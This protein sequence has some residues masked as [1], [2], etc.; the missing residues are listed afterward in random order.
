MSDFHEGRVAA[1]FLM[2][3]R[4]ENV[5]E[6]YESEVVRFDAVKTGFAMAGARLEEYRAKVREDTTTG[7][8]ALK[9]GECAN[10]YIS[11]CVEL[12]KQLFQDT[13]AKRLAA[14]G[15][16]EAMKKAVAEAK[17]AWDAERSKLAE[18][19]AFEAQK[20]QDL[21]TRP[22]GF[23]PEKSSIDQSISDPPAQPKKRKK[24]TA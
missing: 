7:K 12:V 6:A 8:I 5:K 22:V 16:A 14:Y 2:G 20:P 4:L 18:V 13:E 1:T 10:S 21:K 23:L 3:N 17:A 24:T 19:V 15:A 9:E 11:A